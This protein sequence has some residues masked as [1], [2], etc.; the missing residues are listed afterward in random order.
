M[1][2]R[3]AHL[4]LGQEMEASGNRWYG[5]AIL[6]DNGKMVGSMAVMDFPS[7]A[8]LNAW[9]AKEPYVIGDVWRTVEVMKC[10]VKNP[11]KFNKP[12]EFFESRGYK[13]IT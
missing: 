6:D 10:N 8:E 5:A 11:W 13:K 3:E 12:K 9:L 4:R 1:A 2:V 7:E